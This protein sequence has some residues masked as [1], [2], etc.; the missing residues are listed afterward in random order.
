MT[1]R[2]EW[3]ASCWGRRAAA[4]AAFDFNQMWC[5]FERAKLPTGRIS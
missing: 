3:W 5:P 1:D 4:G 2:T